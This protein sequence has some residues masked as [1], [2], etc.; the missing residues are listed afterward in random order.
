[1]MPF[2]Q[3]YYDFSEFQRLM[4]EATV[5]LQQMT[6]M[7]DRMHWQFDYPKYYEEFVEAINDV[8]NGWMSSHC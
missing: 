7:Q 8:K 2:E 1:M 4:E 5:K 3:E 6:H